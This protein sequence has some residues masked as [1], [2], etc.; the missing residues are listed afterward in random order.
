MKILLF[1]SLAINFLFATANL[2]L[3]TTQ[4]FDVT[5]TNAKINI[6]N[7]IIGQSGVIV[8]NLENNSI[9][10]SQAIV[11]HSTNDG[12]QIKFVDV[13]VLKQDAIPTTLLKVSNGDEFI[14]NHLY[15]TS[16]LIAPNEKAKFA[17]K[18]LFPK[19]NFVSEDFFASNLKLNN[20][21]VPT[22][23]T[24]I[25]FAQAQQIGTLFFVV[26]NNLF[27]V[28]SL[29]F[30]VIDTILIPNDDDSTNVPFLT[31]IDEI[32]TGIFNFGFSKNKI[33]N[34]DLYYL[35]LLEILK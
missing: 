21:P 14:L 6:P 26:Q 11:T 27:I 33:E 4:I 29:S 16:L 25:N 32:K 13:D 35:K 2:Q 31:K 3:Q 1:I 30:K 24:F 19:Q 28:D 15:N 9:I 23:E 7:L 18:E 10:L 22:K 17:V 8:R 34:Y 20:T 12:S 5:P